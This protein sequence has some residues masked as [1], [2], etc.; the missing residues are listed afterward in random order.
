[1]FGRSSPVLV[2]NNQPP[3][4]ILIDTYNSA[5]LI[6]RAIQSALQQTY[7]A[8]AVEILVVDDG[9]R[10][11]TA[12][13][14]RRYGDSVRYI[15]KAN[16]G[17]ASTL[18]EGFRHA[19]GQFVCLLDGDDFFYPNKVR[20]VVEVF[21]TRPEV[22]LVYNRYDIVAEDLSM[23]SRQIP[24]SMTAGNLKSRTLLGYS[25]GC[26]T[27]AMS[28]R[29]S[30][31]TPIVIPEDVFR[32]SADFFLATIL[33]L[34]T[35]VGIVRDSSSAWV[36]HGANSL[37]LNPSGPSADLNRSHREAIVRYVENELGE[38]LVTYLGRDGLAAGLRIPTSPQDR[39]QTYLHEA[40]EIARADVDLKI[41]LRAQAKLA[42]SLAL[43][44]TQY[45]RLKALVGSDR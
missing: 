39:V 12:E 31:V 24:P 37:L 19:T 14:V 27:S 45:Q 41:K 32:V 30:V 17:Q 6:D 18:N 22:G 20:A 2:S 35:E 1:V 33:P 13:V 3:V 5:H 7:P 23:L 25:W 40:V 43:G 9:S 15:R 26:V 10:D 29:R 8:D 42:L 44:N 21:E 4:T 11:N 38:H 34:L 16:G 36:A 28:I